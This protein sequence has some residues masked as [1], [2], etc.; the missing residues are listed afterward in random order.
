[1]VPHTLLSRGKTLK[2]LLQFLFFF[3]GETFD[4]IFDLHLGFVWAEP[5]D[6]AQ[7]ATS[8]ASPFCSGFVNVHPLTTSSVSNPGAHFDVGYVRFFDEGGGF[9]EGGCWVGLLD[10]SSFG[11]DACSQRDAAG[12]CPV[13]LLWPLVG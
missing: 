9:V 3:F 1:M 2:L 5:A 6:V 13:F 10:M 8:E 12:S 7:F 4:N 11:F